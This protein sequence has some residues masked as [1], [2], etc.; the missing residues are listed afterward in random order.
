M[1]NKI[2]FYEDPR[3]MEKEILA[4]IS[5]GSPVFQAKKVMEEN[6]FKC[7]YLQDET[8]GTT[9]EKDFLH[10]DFSKLLLSKALLVSRRWL[11]AIDHQE[12]KVVNV[13]VSTGLIGL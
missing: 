9:E 12:G 3:L 11:V 6:R 4:H 7:R 13:S 5:V 1:V 10:C 2:K 8:F